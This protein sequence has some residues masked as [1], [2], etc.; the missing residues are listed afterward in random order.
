[1]SLS[2]CEDDVMKSSE[3]ICLTTSLM[4]WLLLSDDSAL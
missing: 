3:L 2:I 1:M 4:S